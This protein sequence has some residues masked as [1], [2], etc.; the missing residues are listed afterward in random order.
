MKRILLLLSICL[1][2]TVPAIA[3]E[4]HVGTVVDL[5]DQHVVLETQDGEQTIRWTADL[6]RPMNLEAG[7]AIV[8]RLDASNKPTELLIVDEQVQ[9]AN[10]LPDTYHAIAGTLQEVNPDHMIL[11]TP[12]GQ[13]AF[14][15]YPEKL[16]PPMPAE[17][18]RVAV[19]Y[20]ETGTTTKYSQ[21]AASEIIELDD[22]FTFGADNVEVAYSDI[23]EPE[24]ETQ[25]AE[26]SEPEMPE[27]MQDEA[28]QDELTESTYDSTTYQSND[29]QRTLPQTASALPLVGLVGLLAALGWFAL[30][31]L[32]K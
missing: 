21:F 22:S 8:V 26:T 20:R 9:V 32:R 11:K 31:V 28:I 12:S 2:A 3:N 15:I 27:P 30:G 29:S 25:V 19:I 23:L 13:E 24:T 14:I 10:V 4:S 17:G 7:D 1:L 5:D 16:F 18:K 6:E